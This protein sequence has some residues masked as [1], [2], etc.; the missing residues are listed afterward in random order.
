MISSRLNNLTNKNLERFYYKQHQNKTYFKNLIT[1]VIICQGLLKKL[2]FAFRNFNFIFPVGALTSKQYPF[3]NRNWELISLKS[4]DFSDGFG[5]DIRIFLKNNRLI[6]ILPDFNFNQNED[7]WISDKTRF[8]FDGMFSLERNLPFSLYK[9]TTLNYWQ[10]VFNNIQSILYF[11][12]HL[13]RHTGNLLK[14]GIVINNSMDLETIKLLIL[15]KNRYSFINIKKLEKNIRIQ[16]DLEKSFLTNSL[17][18]VTDFELSN[19]CL[20]LNINPRFEGYFFNLKLR[21]AVLK[22]NLKITGLS[23]KINTT[24]P[25]QYIGSNMTILKR[26]VEGN[27]FYCQQLKESVNPIIIQSSELFKR[28]DSLSIEINS[29]KFYLSNLYNKYWNGF[30]VLNTTLSDAGFNSLFKINSL[31]LSDFINSNILHLINLKFNNLN[32]NITKLVELKL[33]YSLNSQLLSIVEQNYIFSKKPTNNK[34]NEFKCSLKLLNKSFFESPGN[35]IN[36]IGSFITP[37]NIISSKINAKTDYSILQTFYNIFNNIKFTN[38]YNINKK[39]NYLTIK[40]IIDFLY[41]PSNFIIVSG[42]AYFQMALCN[43]LYAYS[44]KYL[45]KKRKI[46]STKLYNWLE[47]FFINGKD[48]YS[49]FSL[50]MLQCSLLQRKNINNF[51]Y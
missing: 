42:T 38:N 31:T 37:I 13:T 20:L 48:L 23:S 32:L 22:N 2:D 19:S 24:Y 35:F 34:L 25:I 21:Q 47:D 27:H 50:T 45:V 44:Y 9:N 29:L 28:S 26:I 16:N 18:T 6:K 10:Y 36:T 8:A 17:Q 5:L 15:L 46:Y 51:L 11:Q 40:N 3:I 30:N 4:N 1:I 49:P 39:L 41:L 14:V 7:N 33:L 43:Y 12:D